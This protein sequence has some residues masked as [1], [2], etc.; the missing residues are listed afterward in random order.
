MLYLCGTYVSP[1]FYYCGMFSFK[2]SMW[3]HLF[4]FVPF[5]LL[6]VHYSFTVICCLVLHDGVYL[7]KNFIQKLKLQQNNIPGCSK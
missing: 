2:Y 6:P 1:F 7:L 5:A 3:P 4:H